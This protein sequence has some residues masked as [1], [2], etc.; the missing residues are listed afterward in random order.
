MYYSTSLFNEILMKV[1]DA[2]TY[3]FSRSQLEVNYA[4]RRINFETLI[5]DKQGL[6]KHNHLSVRVSASIG[7]I[8][9]LCLSCR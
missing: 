9:K 5:P 7:S 8:D 6:S 4:I 1:R 2:Y 3:A